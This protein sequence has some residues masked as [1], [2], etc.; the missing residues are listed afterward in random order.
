[1]DRERGDEIPYGEP[2]K[3]PE[4][5]DSADLGGHIPSDDVAR[6]Y[7]ESHIE[8]V[9]DLGDFLE[10]YVDPDWISHGMDAEDMCRHYMRLDPVTLADALVLYFRENT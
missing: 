2:M 1:M 9:D 4:H 3:I 7:C 5:M 10:S 6:A 8:S